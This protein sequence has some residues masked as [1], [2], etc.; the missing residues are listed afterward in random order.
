MVH[1]V[2][3]V[4]DRHRAEGVAVIAA[5]QRQQAGASRA[6]GLQAHLDRDLDGDR[7]GVG[8]EDVLERRRG[9]R[10]QPS[11]QLDRG[12]VGEAAE[13]DVR[14]AI[15]LCARGGVEHRVAV[16]VDRA[17]PRRHSVD[18]L[19]AV[20]QGEPHAARARDEQRRG[21]G[22]HRAV[23]MPDVGVVE[24]QQRTVTSG[25]AHQGSIESDR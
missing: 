8:E 19:A 1:A 12:L 6:G 23:W 3:R 20:G 16:A 11:R 7:A 21:G 14:H 24:R 5:A 10:N 15:Q 9:Q 2:E 4:A 25:V 17:P 18:Q 22:R 13:H